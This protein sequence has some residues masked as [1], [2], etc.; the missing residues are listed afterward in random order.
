[1]TLENPMHGRAGTVAATM[2]G[3]IAVLVFIIQ[4]GYVQALVERGGLDG[5]AA[6]Y[7]ASAEM[8]GIAAVTVLMSLLAH[9][10]GWRPLLAGAVLFEV[11]GNLA[12]LWRSDLE[13][14]LVARFAAGLGAGT[15]ASLSFAAIGQTRYPDRYF[16]FLI[17][18]ILVYGAVGLWALPMLLEHG[19]LRAFYLVVAALAL[20]GLVFVRHMPANGVVNAEDNVIATLTAPNQ[21]FSILSI[22][23][24]FLGCGLLWAYLALIGVGEGLSSAA[25]ATGL[26]ISQIAGIAG[27]LGVGLVGARMGRFSPLIV[28]IVICAA[29]TA[30]LTTAGPKGALLFTLLICS[31]NFAW[32]AVQPIY[33]SVAASYDARGRLITQM[34]AAQMIGL[35]AGP[36]LGGF[37]FEQGGLPPIIWWSSALLAVGAVLLAPVILEA[38]RT[39]RG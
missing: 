6:G 23:T 20:G 4:P 37:I 3:V 33:L 12:C 14:L 2:L 36:F 17:M 18:W 28:G 34:V 21:M 25:V 35:A 27:A 32:N 9:R 29:A 24:F 16:G 39:A 15:L 10:V 26:G 11:G 30:G 5:A 22:F 19:G 1:M 38:A 8:A 13:W 7:V 31:F